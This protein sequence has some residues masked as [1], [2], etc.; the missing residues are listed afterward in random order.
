MPCRRS[1]I[2]FV[3]L[4]LPKVPECLRSRGRFGFGGR[5]I[6][7]GRRFGGVLRPVDDAA[8]GGDVAFEF[9]EELRKVA[10]RTVLDRGAGEAEAAARDAAI[11]KAA[12][13]FCGVK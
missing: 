7:R 6:A 13:Q 2:V 3:T 1:V 5:D 11:A 12:E 8:A 9:F 10:H 4:P